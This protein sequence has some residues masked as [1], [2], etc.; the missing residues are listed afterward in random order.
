MNGPLQF[1]VQ[2]GDIHGA[3]STEGHGPPGEARGRVQGP[4]LQQ[5]LNK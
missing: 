5:A 2:D 1:G 4:G 3:H